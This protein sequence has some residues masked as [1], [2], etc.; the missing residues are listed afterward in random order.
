MKLTAANLDWS[1][2]NVHDRISRLWDMS[3]AMIIMVDD[4]ELSSLSLM[5]S[6][7]ILLLLNEDADADADVEVA[8]VEQHRLYSHS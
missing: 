2:V 8:V 3:P 6:S 1:V 7:M 5:V 4:F